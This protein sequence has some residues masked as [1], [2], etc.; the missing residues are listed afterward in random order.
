[1][2]KKGKNEVSILGGN[3]VINQEKVS[4]VGGER[5][6]AL[7][8]RYW[9]HL[10][11][12]DCFLSFTFLQGSNHPEKTLTLHVYLLQHLFLIT[13]RLHYLII[14]W[15][16]LF[17]LSYF[18]LA[19]KNSCCSVRANST[20]G[21]IIVVRQLIQLTLRLAP[22]KYQFNNAETL[23]SCVANTINFRGKGTLPEWQTV[24]VCCHTHKKKYHKT[25][26]TMCPD[27]SF[28]H[29]SVLQEHNKYQHFVV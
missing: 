8:M 16:S 21:K 23:S 14:Q 18:P 12:Q 17:L 7:L 9:L 4:I 15:A 1:M 20:D 6:E 3:S 25:E 13:G 28:P 2:L 5:T 24:N 10:L 11:H 29:N 26:E 19:A 27:V 22:Y